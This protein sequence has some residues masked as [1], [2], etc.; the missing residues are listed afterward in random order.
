MVL[1]REKLLSTVEQYLEMERASEE[2]HEYIDGY[3]YDMAGE[4]PDHSRINVNLLTI[5]NLQLRG[6]PCEAFSPNMKIRSGPF[7]KEQK[8]NKGM[9]SYADF[10]IVCGEPQF[11]DTFRDVLINPTVIIE[12]LSESTQGFDRDEKF[13]RYRT[14]ISSLQDYLLVS[15]TLPMIQVYSRQPGG[16]LMTEALGLESSIRV[17]SIDCHL[18]LSEVYD[19]V[20]FPSLEEPAEEHPEEMDAIAKND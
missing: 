5:L 15:Q 14:H 11:H 13:R 16:W 6:K 19:R 2:R 17:P 8:T 18:P 4:S 20:V 10:S 1:P 7:F 12:I 9:F 3:V